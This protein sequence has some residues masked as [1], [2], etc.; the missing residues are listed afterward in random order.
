[1]SKP[2]WQIKP[3]PHKA[4]LMV[5]AYC[6]ARRAG[7]KIPEAQAFAGYYLERKYQ[8]GNSSCHWLL[9]KTKG[10]GWRMAYGRN[11]QKYR[12]A[13][14]SNT[15]LLFL[16][17]CEWLRNVLTKDPGEAFHFV[18]DWLLSICDSAH[19]NRSTPWQIMADYYEEQND[20]DTAF[21][22]RLLGPGLS[23]AM[24]FN[25]MA[26]RIREM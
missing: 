9:A 1:M 15:D 5:S 7:A 24:G 21:R 20:Q 13:F 14:K 18:K 3:T 25:E 2:I 17:S 19:L 11:A 6:A 4:K 10:A 12:L 26:R 22:L 16:D 8:D 23:V